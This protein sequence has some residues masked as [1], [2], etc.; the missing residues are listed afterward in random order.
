M[1][2]PPLY[3][4]YEGDGAMVCQRPNLADKHYVVGMNYLLVE[5]HERSEVS[6]RHFFA[7]VNELWQSIPD[8]LAGE[9]P[10]AEHLRKKMLINTGFCDERDIV[11]N[12]KADALRVAALSRELDEYAVV[13]V[14]DHVVRVYR[15]KS[16]S[17]KAMGKA[18]FQASKTAV[19]DAIHALLGI[20]EAAAA[21]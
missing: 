21:A 15:A 3:Y 17:T 10:T 13:V 5:H 18:D 8:H 7:T 4:R 12:T 9:Y 14:R 11:L 19:L 6:H 20:D 16:Q 2:I 1:S